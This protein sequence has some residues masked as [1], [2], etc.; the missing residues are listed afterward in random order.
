LGVATFEADSSSLISS[1]QKVFK[2][3]KVS[4]RRIF[5]IFKYIPRLSE[6]HKVYTNMYVFFAGLHKKLWK[7]LPFIG[8]SAEAEL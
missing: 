6:K 2:Y 3:G 8:M 1:V 4:N 5:F 7:P